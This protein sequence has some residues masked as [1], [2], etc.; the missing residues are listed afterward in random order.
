MNDLRTGPGT[1]L[2]PLVLALGM[3]CGAQAGAAEEGADAGLPGLVDSA[4]GGSWQEVSVEEAGAARALFEALLAGD[5]G[6]EVAARL[7]ALDLSLRRLPTP[8]GELLVVS[9]RDGGLRGRGMFAIRPAAD[10]EVILQAPHSRSDRGTGE[11]TALWMQQLPFRAAAWNTLHRDAADDGRTALGSDLARARTSY[12]TALAEAALGTLAEPIIIQVHGFDAGRRTSDAGRDSAMIIS[13]GTELPEP[14]ALAR[15]GCMPAAVGT[16]RLYP[17]DVQ[18]LGGTLN[19][20]GRLLRARRAPGFVHVEMAAPTRTALR[21]DAD[22]REAV[23]LC[24]L[25]H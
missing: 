12:F 15:S 19:P 8:A 18:E 5:E 9:E 14:P 25:G 23:G 11:L 24:L 2:L 21:E 3:G 6:D 1:L 10:A 16:V 22:L 4:R 7:A 17:L 13:S 20:V